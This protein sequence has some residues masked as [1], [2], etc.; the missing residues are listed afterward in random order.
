MKFPPEIEL[1]FENI[2]LSSQIKRAVQL[3]REVRDCQ[4]KVKQ[5]AAAL[6]AREG[7]LEAARKALS[8]Q[9]AKS[10]DDD[11]NFDDDLD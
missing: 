5:A 7:D 9:L 11:A 3:N 4:R 2:E 8:E 10:D 1:E 6:K